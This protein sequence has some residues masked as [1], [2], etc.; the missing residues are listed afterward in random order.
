MA[1][2]KGN[3][4]A[5]T[6]VRVDDVR[7]EGDMELASRLS[8]LGAAIVDTIILGVPFYVVFFVVL[9][10]P[11]G[12]AEQASQSVLSEFLLTLGLFLGA[13]VIYAVI[14]WVPLEANGQ[15]WGKKLLNIRIVRSDGSPVGAKRALFVRYLPI[16]SVSMVPFIGNIIGLVNALMIFRESRK[17]LHD[18]IADTVVVKA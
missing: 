17:C 15:S 1:E 3:I 11:F 6:E 10:D 16:Q 12:L 13:F 4:Y 5:P 2:D 18:D 8:R 7:A 9:S 14:N